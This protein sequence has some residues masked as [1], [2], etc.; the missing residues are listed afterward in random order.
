M[1]RVSKSLKSLISKVSEG[2][3]VVNLFPRM[4]RPLVK[5]NVD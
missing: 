2:T 5:I 1:G 4:E 3:I